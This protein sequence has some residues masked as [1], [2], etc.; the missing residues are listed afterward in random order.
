M[1]VEVQKVS[2]DRFNLVV[3]GTVVLQAIERSEVRYIIQELDNKI[4]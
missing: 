2:K 4:S 3:N 1:E